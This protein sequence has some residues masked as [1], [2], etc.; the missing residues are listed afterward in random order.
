MYSN[1]VGFESRFGFESVGFGFNSRQRGGF[2]F[3][4][5]EKGVDSEPRCL[6]S[7]MIAPSPTTE[8][9]RD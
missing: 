5:K 4:F 9:R 7:H 3:G 6:D 1:S 8:T 2:R